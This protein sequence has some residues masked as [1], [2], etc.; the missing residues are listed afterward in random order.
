MN[1]M[2]VKVTWTRTTHPLGSS[3]PTHEFKGEVVASLHEFVPT[4]AKVRGFSDTPLASGQVVEVYNKID[5]STLRRPVTYDLVDDDG[6]RVVNVQDYTR[7]NPRSFAGLS[8]ERKM[9]EIL[10]GRKKPYQCR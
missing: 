8:P 1:E 4:G 2:I 6:T 10:S 3:N 7:Y 5:V 9:E